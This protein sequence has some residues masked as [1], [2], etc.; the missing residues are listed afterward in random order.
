[1]KQ[2]PR[3]IKRSLTYAFTII[4][5]ISTIVGLWGYTVKD[6]NPD[7]SWWKWGLIL[8]GGFIILALFIFIILKKASHRA[9]ST[10]INGKPVTIKVGDIF[11][12]TGWKLIPCNE[13]FDTQVDDRIIAHNT[14]NGK[15]IDDHVTD[16]EDLRSV[17]IAAKDGS[18]EFIPFTKGGKTVFPLGRL[19]PYKDFLMLAFSH[20][21]ENDTAYIG[22]GEYEQLLLRMWAEVR[23]VY[24]AKPVSLP[25]IGGGVTTIKGLP[26]KNY[27]ALLKCMLCTLRSSKFQPDQGLTIILTQDV[28]DQIDMNEIKEEF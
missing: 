5:G 28:I 21:D 22:I 24:A 14:L 25:L 10:S 27:T 15:M 18:S 19:I 8:L 26:E 4:T 17:I 1:M 23:R 2:I 20:F 3:T 16:I 7:L 12:E 11:A 6:I 13:R 9:Y